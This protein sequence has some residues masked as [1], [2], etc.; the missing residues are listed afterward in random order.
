MHVIKNPFLL[1]NE[2]IKSGIYNFV[3]KQWLA[4]ACEMYCIKSHRESN[5]RN[6]TPNWRSWMYVIK[7]PY[8]LQ[9][10]YIKSSIYIF[11]V[12]GGWHSHAKC[13]RR[14]THD[15]SYWIHC[16]KSHRESNTGNNIS[17]WRSWMHV[18]KNPF[19]LQNEYI[20][21]GICNFLNGGWYSHAKYHRRATHDPSY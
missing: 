1:Q 18:I 2:Y 10:E 21:S 6:N 14:A 20:K 15:P 8:L 7:N 3:C 17:N 12:N 11:F 9:N 19:L 16:I 4:I 13:H 5:T